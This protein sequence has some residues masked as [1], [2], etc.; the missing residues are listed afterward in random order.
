MPGASLFWIPSLESDSTIVCFPISVLVPVNLLH[1][2][3]ALACR[4][5]ETQKLNMGYF[6]SEPTDFSLGTCSFAAETAKCIS[7][8]FEICPRLCGIRDFES[9]PGLKCLL[10]YFSGRSK[11]HTKFCWRRGSSVNL[12]WKQNSLEMRTRDSTADTARRNFDFIAFKLLSLMDHLYM[13][14]SLG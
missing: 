2:P 6:F 11:S 3:L 10:V 1:L 7:K 8:K 13:N 12:E 4:F 5:W 14:T 9:L